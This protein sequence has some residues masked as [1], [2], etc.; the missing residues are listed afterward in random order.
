MTT[1]IPQTRENHIKFD[2]VFHFFL[3]PLC[4]A[5]P[6]WSV[7]HLMLHP[8]NEAAILM[9]LTLL[10][11]VLTVKTRVYSLKVQDR[12]IRLEERLR[13]A[14]L[15]SEP[16]RGRITELTEGQLI[17]LRFASDAE[18]PV[19][20]ARALDEKLDRKAIKAAVQQ[21]RGDYFRI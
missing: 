8:S 9:A 2:P 21:W 12:V 19:L 7:V 18:V 6:I 3:A 16:Y 11:L 4:L 20:A 14:S 5:L 13:L 1:Q 10:T 15:L 17:A